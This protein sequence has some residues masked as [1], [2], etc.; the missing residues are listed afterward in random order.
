VWAAVVGRTHALGVDPTLLALSC[1]V[2]HHRIA[3]TPSD[4]EPSSAVWWVRSP[5]I[6]GGGVLV[7]VWANEGIGGGRVRLA[8][9]VRYRDHLLAWAAQTDGA[10]ELIEMRVGCPVRGRTARHR[11]APNGTGEVMS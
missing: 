4:M 2:T 7:F 3:T 10:A 11:N 9:H 1:E 8:R 6:G 5:S